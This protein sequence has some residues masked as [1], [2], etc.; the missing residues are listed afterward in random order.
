[1]FAPEFDFER[2]QFVKQGR[3]VLGLA[4]VKALAHPRPL[5]GS[6][7]SLESL[8]FAIHGHGTS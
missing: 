5:A 3:A 6:P 2:Q 1:V 7:C 8:A 4:G